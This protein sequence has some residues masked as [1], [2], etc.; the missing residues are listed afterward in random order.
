[1]VVLLQ[2]HEAAI[3]APVQMSHPGTIG[4]ECI[5]NDRVDK[6]P[7]GLVERIEQAV[8]RGEFAF[9][10]VVFAIGVAAGFFVE[11]GFDGQNDVKSR[12]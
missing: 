3:T 9:M 11:Y 2:D 12:A 1:M 6:T 10:A 5:A 4:I 7:P 8:G